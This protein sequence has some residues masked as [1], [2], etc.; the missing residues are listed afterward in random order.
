MYVEGGA[1]SD[2]DDLGFEVKIISKTARMLEILLNFNK[3]L[4]VSKDYEEKDTLVLE[5]FFP[6]GSSSKTKR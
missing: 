1:Y 4:A 2:S 6:D 5:F 3:P